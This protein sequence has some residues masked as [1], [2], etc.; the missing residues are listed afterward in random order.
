MNGSIK[1]VNLIQLNIDKIKWLDIVKLDHLDTQMRQSILASWI[2]RLPGL[3]D[4][5]MAW[6]DNSKMRTSGND[7][8][9]N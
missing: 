7:L 9:K 8:L 6:I 3:V 1:A 5:Q 4:I 2:N